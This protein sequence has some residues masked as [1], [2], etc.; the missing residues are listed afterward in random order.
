[1]L[2]RWFTQIILSEGSDHLRAAE[3]EFSLTG[4]DR[5]VGTGNSSHFLVCGRDMIVDA[6]GPAGHLQHVDDRGGSR[7]AGH[8]SVRRQ[9]VPAPRSRRTLPAAWPAIR[10]HA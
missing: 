6:Q 3:I 5:D 9:E 10:N 8:G 2:D 1:M 7:D 4:D